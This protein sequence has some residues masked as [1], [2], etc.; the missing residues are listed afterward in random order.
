MKK[1]LAK[2]KRPLGKPMKKQLAQFKG[3]R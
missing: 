3:T 2:F 1:Q